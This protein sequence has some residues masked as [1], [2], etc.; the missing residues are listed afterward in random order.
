MGSDSVTVEFYGI[1][2][3]RAGCGEV[4]VAPGPLQTILEEVQRL[5]PRFTDLR[6]AHGG[7]SPHYR[8]SLDGQR[9]LTDVAE[10]LPGASRL[11]VLSADMGG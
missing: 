2:R 8:V 9:F 11:I 7:I 3:E 6:T 5:C 1:P 4:T 10:F